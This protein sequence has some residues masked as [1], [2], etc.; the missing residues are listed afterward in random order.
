MPYEQVKGSK[1]LVSYLY[2]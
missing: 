2:I 1:I